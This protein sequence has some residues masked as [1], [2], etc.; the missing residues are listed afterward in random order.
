MLAKKHQWIDRLV[1]S[2]TQWID[3]VSSKNVKT[4]FLNKR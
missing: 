3:Y 4:I 2:E 1:W